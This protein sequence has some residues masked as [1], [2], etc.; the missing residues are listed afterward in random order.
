MHNHKAI[1]SYIILTLIECYRLKAY[2][3]LHGADRNQQRDIRR[4]RPVFFACSKAIVSN[5]GVPSSPNATFMLSGALL[6]RTLLVVLISKGD[7]G[8]IPFAR[9]GGGLAYK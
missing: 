5:I 8:E 9:L 4:N 7:C 3:S 2:S 6:R 1:E